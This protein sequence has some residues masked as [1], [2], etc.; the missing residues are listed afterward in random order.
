MRLVYIGPGAS[1]DAQRP[2]VRKNKVRVQRRVPVDSERYSE[3]SRQSLRELRQEGFQRSQRGSV[4]GRD[5]TPFED[6]V[7]E[8]DSGGSKKK[9]GS[10]SDDGSEKSGSGFVKKALGAGAAALAIG[11][12]GKA[13]TKAITGRGKSDDGSEKSKTSKRSRRS[14]RSD[15]LSEGGRRRFGLGGRRRGG[16]SMAAAGP[17]GVEVDGVEYGDYD[18]GRGGFRERLFG[19]GARDELGPRR[20]G[21]NP[22][23]PFDPDMNDREYNE[24]VKQDAKR[25]FGFYA[26]PES[27]AFVVEKEGRY[28]RILPPGKHR[29]AFG[30]DVAHV[31]SLAVKSL[32][33]D[34]PFMTYDREEVGIV[35]HMMVRVDNPVQAS[36]AADDPLKNIM[37]ITVDALRSQVA[38]M[39]VERCFDEAEAIGYQTRMIVNQQARAWGWVCLRVMLDVNPSMDIRRQMEVRAQQVREGIIKLESRRREANAAR[40]TQDIE[41][42]QFQRSRYV[43]QLDRI[44]RS[45]A[46][47]EAAVAR[48]SADARVIQQYVDILDSPNG[49]QAIEYALS[50]KVMNEGRGP[51]HAADLARAHEM[52]MRGGP[53][54]GMHPDIPLGSRRS[55]MPPP[56]PP[57]MGPHPAMSMHRG[58]P[59][60]MSMRDGVPPDMSMRGGIPPE[61]S[62][63]GGVPPD[64]SMQGGVPPDM[65]MRGGVPPELSM[66]GG[67]PPELSLRGGV[68]PESHMPM[69]PGGPSMG[70]GGFGD[71]HSVRGSVR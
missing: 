45:Q 19:R 15:D 13:L 66:R 51:I 7:D 18:R 40:I 14:R 62:M 31:H 53:L 70:M 59:P 8:G 2:Q 71:R 48:A 68:P 46:E 60:G 33:F 67:I 47:A 3:L 37:L 1:K 36:Y 42:E 29:L 24:Y 49:E 61:L 43:E 23:G 34:Q 16:A 55:G 27:H 52:S 50:A 58:V 30:E 21:M 54:P 17:Q 5:R 4:Y 57:G 44:H 35:V 41:I 28:L 32:R 6:E 9:D 22:S 38:R 26:V 39:P 11:T 10:D 63:R 64:M 12:A 56:P 69:H 25:P 65:S 20:P